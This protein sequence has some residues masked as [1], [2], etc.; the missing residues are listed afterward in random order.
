MLNVLVVTPDYPPKLVGGIG[1]YVYNLYRNMGECNINIVLIPFMRS[2]EGL[3]SD[4]QVKNISIDVISPNGL[5]YSYSSHRYMYW[6]EYN[7]AVYEAL[8]CH[9]NERR[10]HFDLIHAHSSY[11]AFAIKQIR[12]ALNIPVVYTKHGVANSLHHKDYVNDLY[13]MVCADFVIAPSNYV[14]DRLATMYSCLTRIPQRVILS[15]TN[16]SNER[17]EAKK[18]RLVIFCGRLVP[19]KGCKI[20]L[21]ALRYII[22][23]YPGQFTHMVKIIGDGTERHALENFAAGN[24]LS[25]IVHFLGS[26]DHNE[27]FRHMEEAELFVMPSLREPFGLTVLEAMSK[28]CVPIVSN[29]GALPEIVSDGVD[30]I[31]FKCGDSRDLAQKMIALVN[32]KTKLSML[33]DNGGKKVTKFDWSITAKE[34]YEVY[35]EVLRDR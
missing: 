35:Q 30:G 23:H 7:L 32:N 16:I 18:K 14:R 11:Y 12:E 31:L 22:E 24:S 28:G 1:S 6:M 27:V 4:D 20:F 33:R 3:L 25:E 34:T 10:S 9:L 17:T 2:F 29:S 15:G 19:Q 13:M 21:Q 26:C 5:Q 8:L